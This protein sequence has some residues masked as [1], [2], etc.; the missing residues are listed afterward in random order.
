M[1]GRSPT[2]RPGRRLARATF[3]VLL[4]LWWLAFAPSA[5]AVPADISESFDAGDGHTLTYTVSGVQPD[6]N[7]QPAHHTGTVTADRVTLS[8]TATFVIGEGVVT[9]LGMSA[10][11]AVGDQH[12]EASWPPEGVSGTVSNTTITFPFELTVEVPDPPEPIPGSEPTPNAT[13]TPYAALSFSVSSRNCNDW[14]V[15]GGPSADGSF[16]VFPGGSQTHSPT[17]IAAVGAVAAAAA[18]AAALTGGRP[19]TPEPSIAGY[20]LQLSGRAFRVSMETPA[21]LQATAWRVDASGGMQPAPEAA[22]RVEVPPGVPWLRVLPGQGSGA[23]SGQI[24]L[25]DQPTT[26]QVVLTVVGSA[27]T[28]EI[29]ENVTVA[30]ETNGNYRAELI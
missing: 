4:G 2:S 14:G 24:S 6:E 11:I 8:G 15:C 29:V 28:G 30:I 25:V 5:T 17:W 23:L 12:A 10:S 27:P 22:L 20:V 26:E 7:D 21:T 18:A 1:L 13:P 19:A 16:A 3:C 9:N